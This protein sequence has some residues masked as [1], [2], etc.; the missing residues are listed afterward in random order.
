MLAMLA[1]FSLVSYV[2]RMNISVA[3]KFMMPE[4]GLSEIQ[5]GQV[6]SSFLLAYALFQIPAG[7]LGD[8]RGPRSVLTAAALSWGAAT[9]LT[10][11]VPGLVIPAGTGVFVSLLALRFFLGVGEAATFPVAALAIANWIPE[12][13]RAM[14]NSVMIAGLSL[15]SAVTPPLISWLMVSVGW[16]ESFYLTSALAF[17]LA[18]LWWRYAPDSPARSPGVSRQDRS[19]A[20]G[21]MSVSWWRLLKDRNICLISLSYF[22]VGYVIYIFVFWFYLYLV[23]VRGFSVLSGG[24]FT[25]LPFVMSSILTPIGGTLCDLISRRVGRRWGRRIIAVGGLTAA[26]VALLYG[27]QAQTPYLAIAA[28]SLSVGFVEFTEG[29]FWSSTIDVAGPHAGAACGI[30]NMLGNLGGVVST[31]LV[32]ILVKHFGWMFALG[33]GSALALIGGLIWFGVQVE[34]TLDKEKMAVIERSV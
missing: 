8:R 21:S 15:G 4:L 17:V 30:L 19:A 13:K 6:F 2:Q 5:M 32:P 28:L 14:A 3:A 24:L 7:V 29:A 23:D 9:F 18:A 26:S 16:R 34:K 22:F 1:S 20:A 11:F 25:S 27:A 33:T 12:T 10:G 31:A